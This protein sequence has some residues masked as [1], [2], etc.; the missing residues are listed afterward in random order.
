MSRAPFTLGGVPYPLE[1][2]RSFRVIVPA[3]DPL[4]APAV[5]QVTYSCHVFS[6]KWHDGLSPDRRFKDGSETRAFCPARYGC[7]IMLPQLVNA[8]V[9]GKAYEN[10]DSKGA[11]NHF[12]Y[13]EADG[14]PYPI[15]F[16]LGRA[17][18]I[19]GAHGILHVISA[20]QNTKLVARNRLQ[21]VKFARLVHQKCP[22]PMAGA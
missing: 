1:H 21:A 22:P 3:K 15:F 11:K 2:L 19:R 20:Y 18:N 16:R 14:V 9:G 4:L 8:H 5:L 12:F 6:E 7:S 13:A 17:N 10:K